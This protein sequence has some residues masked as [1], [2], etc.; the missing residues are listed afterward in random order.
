M[1]QR[2]IRFPKTNSFFLFGPRG[3]G[4]TTWIKEQ[5][6][7][8]K[9]IFFNFLDENLLKDLA[10]SSLFLE[11]QISALPQPPDWI[12]LDEIQRAPNVLNWVHQM[13]EEKKWKFVLT[14][15]SARKLKRGAANLL[16]G[17]AFIRHLF[18][19]TSLEMG[20]DFILENVLQFG[21]LPK[22]VLLSKEDRIDFLKAYATTY[23]K[24]EI[25][26][27]QIVRNID[28][29][30]LFLE[31][32]AQQDTQIL[33][34]SKIAT[35]IGSDPKT[36]ERYYQILTDTL[37]GFLL[38]PYERSLRKRQIQHPKFYFYDLG[39]KQSLLNTLQ[40]PI[41]AHGYAFGKAFE[42]FIINE[43]YRYNEYYQKDFRFFYLKTKDGVEVDLIVERPGDSPVFI[44]IKS[45]ERLDPQ[46]PK[47]LEKITEKVKN[48]E[49]RIFCRE[50]KARKVG[51]VRILP[52]QEGIKE[53]F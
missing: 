12:I 23:L 18:P 48:C 15:S 46:A 39:V 22:T 53:L 51:K 32:S 31:C 38:E 41:Q 49:L 19:L 30:R 36:V 1:Y 7:N 6:K 34:Y 3:S 25:R 14:G 10:H 9:I 29:F 26:E 17:R 20:K 5:F 27:E 35:Q 40:L 44:E 43:C 2:L 13:I 47:K 42:N 11:E 24:E 52:W 16:A 21:S 50:R 8:K 37:V 4:K 28:P 33:N 45:S